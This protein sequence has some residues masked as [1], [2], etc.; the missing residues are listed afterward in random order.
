MVRVEPAL[1]APQGRRLRRRPDASAAASRG[2]RP[3]ASRLAADAAPTPSAR[4]WAGPAVTFAVEVRPAPRASARRSGTWSSSTPPPAPRF[5]VFSVNHDV[6]EG[7][8]LR[9]DARRTGPPSQLHAASLA[10]TRRGHAAGPAG[11]VATLSASQAPPDELT[12]TRI[13]L[14]PALAGR[15]RPRRPRRRARR[16][17]RRS[18][19]ARRPVAPGCRRPASASTPSSDE[20]V[21][22][23]RGPRRSRTAARC[24]ASR[25]SCCPRASPAATGARRPRHAAPA[26]RSPRTLLVARRGDDVALLPA[27]RLLVATATG[28]LDAPA[29]ARDDLRFYV[30]DDRKMYRPGRG[31]AGQGLDPARGRRRGGRRRAAGAAARDGRLHASSDSQGNEVDEGAAAAQRARRLRP[32]AQAAAD[33]EPRRRDVQL[34]GGRAG[35]GRAGR[36]EHTHAFRC[37]SSAGPSSRYGAARAKGRTSSATRADVTVAAAY[38]A[39]GGAARAPTSPGA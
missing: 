33:H 37:R 21:A 11:A 10:A 12:E 9:R 8:G 36:R 22:P 23:R 34:A 19:G 15:P 16:G 29:S 32:D 35:R 3:I 13:D 28:E 38:Y 7:A 17:R 27:E 14:A 6:A 2:A 20:P 18:S 25:W 39:G 24:R 5:S 1:P 26:P 30:F 4:R 31:G